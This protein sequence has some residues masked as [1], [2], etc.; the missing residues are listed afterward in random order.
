MSD[1]IP[2]ELQMEIITRVS[3]LKSLVRLRSV[4]KPWKSFIDSSDFISGYG[5]RHTQ[6]HHSLLLRYIDSFEGKMKYICFVD[7]DNDTFTQQ[8][9]FAPTL[10]MLVK[11]LTGD[12][13][14]VGSSYGLW[15]F[16]MKKESK[17]EMIVLWN[18]SIRK[19][20]GILL[21]NHVQTG[22]VFGFAVCPVTTDPTIVKIMYPWKV[23]I[24]TLS[25]KRW[26]MT[27]CSNLPRN[28]IRFRQ[29]SH[30]IGRCIYWVAYEVITT[31]G[32]SCIYYMIVSLD[33]VAKEFRVVD[34]P[35]N[36]TIRFLESKL[37]ISKLRESLVL[38]VPR[39]GGNIPACA[40][41]KMEHDGSFTKLFTFNTPDKEISNVLGFRKNGKPVMEIQWQGQGEHFGIYRDNS[42][43]GV[44][45]QCSEHIN[46][47]GIYGIEDT[48]FM[49]FYKESLLLLDHSDGCVY[50]N[51]G[52]A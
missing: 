25:S 48:F 4:S 22:H 39:N 15:C 14:V 19:S 11:E 24:F 12:S 7:D 34:V 36:L 46:D 38:F 13:C 43:L 16:Y 18:P 37:F 3:D 51:E 47:L 10:P 31:M 17:R 32:V 20:I 50:P 28:S 6:P 9:D 29:P 2:F 41:W 30:V 5:A 45:E 26:T 33:L 52:A 40:V 23:E 1:N 42:A 35:N 21:P 27:P 49:T 8:Q 44:Y